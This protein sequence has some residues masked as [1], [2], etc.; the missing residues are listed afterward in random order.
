[1]SDAEPSHLGHAWKSLKQGYQPAGQAVD[2]VE[3]TVATMSK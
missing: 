2:E 1:M 3:E